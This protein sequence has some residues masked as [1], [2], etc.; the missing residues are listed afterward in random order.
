[1]RRLLR[2]LRR[3]LR[4]RLVA[5]FL[6]L[7]GV[8]VLIVGSIVYVRAT[9]D[10]TSSVYDRLDAVAG[11]KASQLGSFL[12]E[13]TRNVVFVAVIPGVGDDTRTFL[14]P[15][16]G[17]SA[18]AAAEAD[19]RQILATDVAQ[20]A[21][22]EEIY[23][24]D[25]SG[26]VRLSTLPQDEGKSVADQGFFTTGQSRTIVQNA[27]TSPLSG[28]PTITVATPMFDRNGAGA[29]VA[30]VAANIS[31]QRV[32]N[33]ILDRA[34]LGQTGQ[35]FLVGPDGKLVQGTTGEGGNIGRVN[36]YAVDQLVAQQS[37][38]ALYTSADG[39]P[40]IGV[41]QWLAEPPGRAGGRDDPGRGIRLGAA[42]GADDPRGRD[43][44]G[45]RA[46]RRDLDR[47]PARDAADPLARRDGGESPG[48]RP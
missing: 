45:G 19:L 48:R 26:V 15:A 41:Y 39:V 4:A 42:A 40:V 35:A 12:D 9:N 33:I 13:Q 8:T 18:R 44:L 10:L 2:P 34:G 43:R 20:T 24:V 32:D 27:Y 47:R 17:A 30:V 6:L 29:R 23:I 5:Y 14:D 7:S 25:L 36:S 1:M 38:Q 46:G 28:R 21:D 3:S 37:G 16:A 31:L 22:A 11:L